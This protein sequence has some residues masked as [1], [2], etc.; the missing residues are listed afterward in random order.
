MQFLYYR[1]HISAKSARTG[2]WN[3]CMVWVCSRK[4]PF[5][6][7]EIETWRGFIEKQENNKLIYFHVRIVI[8]MVFTRINVLCDV[9]TR[10]QCN[11]KS[12]QSNL[13]FEVKYF[14]DRA[15]WKSLKIEAVIFILLRCARNVLF[16]SYYDQTWHCTG[17][18]GE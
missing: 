4:K 2:L 14:V 17:F 12:K 18:D 10:I 11:L 13:Q 5:L 6:Q 1:W 9:L 3:V 15:G 7:K 8:T 16:S